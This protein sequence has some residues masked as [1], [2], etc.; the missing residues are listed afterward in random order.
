MANISNYP[1][2]FRGGALIKNVPLFDMIDGNVYWVDNGT[3]GAGNPGTFNS[4]LDSIESA[5]GKCTANN[6]DF[7]MCKS[8]HTEACAGAAGITADVAGVTVLGVGHGDDQAQIRWTAAAATLVISAASV[9]F[10]NM[11]LTAAFA[12]V[13][14]GVNM[15]AVNGIEFIGCRIDEEVATE[16]WVIFGDLADGGDNFKMVGCSYHG[17]DASND[18]VINFAGTHENV[19]FVDNTF[20]H[21]TAQTT[22]AGFI[23]SATQMI[24]CLLQGNRFHT[25][26]AA[27]AN[28]CVEMANAT[29]TGWAIDNMISTVDTDASDANAIE[30]FDV[31]GLMSSGN[32][33]TSGVADTHG[34]ETFTTV[35]DLT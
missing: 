26:T 34:I 27:A 16:N 35:E 12:D 5:F 13:A 2:G 7:I 33:F 29:N 23:V 4:P 17:N 22:G 8:G 3:G 14:E 28:S 31:T 32:M 9:R 11:R 30:C 15:S 6:G 19:Q 21:S 18:T 25:E 10:I 1:S 24:S 20:T